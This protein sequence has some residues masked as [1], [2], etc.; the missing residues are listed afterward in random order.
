MVEPLV[1]VII[2]NYNYGR[3]LTQALD[4]VLTQSYPHKE[5]IVVDDGSTDSSELVVRGYG[6][7][8]KWCQQ[9][10]QGVSSA[11]NRGV[12]ETRGDLVAFLDADDL[13][14]QT[15]LEKQVRKFLDDPELGLVH[16]GVE[17]I[18]SYGKSLRTT[19]DGMSGWVAKEMLLFKESVIVGSGSTALVPRATFES[20]GGF[21]TRLS[22]SADWD[23]GYRVAKLQRIGFV[24]EALVQYR[25]HTS[26]MHANVE[27]MEHDMLIGYAK[28]FANANPELRLLRKRCYGNLHTALAGSFFRAGKRAQFMRHGLKSIWYTPSNFTRIFGF[29]FRWWQ[30]RL[31]IESSHQPSKSVFDQ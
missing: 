22:T 15:K 19:L 4:S 31:R 11:R 14:L 25:V 30:R 8:V 6:E 17:E 20:I 21:D 7:R 5:V 12:G 9:Q 2:P 27:L 3:Y 13:W 26:N 10:R 16:C 1:S 24:A 23:F 29:P 18:D 28:A